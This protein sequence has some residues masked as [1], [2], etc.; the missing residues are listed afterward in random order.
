VKL[1]NPA[2]ENCIARGG[3]HS[4]AKL[5]AGDEYG[6]CLFE[7]NRQCEEWAMLRGHCRVGGRRITGYAAQAARYCAITG[8]D[9]AVTH[10]SPGV[11][12]RGTCTLRNGHVCEANA[13]YRGECR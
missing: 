5:P 6:V 9:Y 2:S 11:E 3:R 13:Y 7:D 1:A 12:E 10:D 8:N 4:V